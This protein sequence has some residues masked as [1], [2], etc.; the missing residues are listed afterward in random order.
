[1]NVELTLTAASAALLSDDVPGA[2]AAVA[3]LTSRQRDQLWRAAHELA[4]GDRQ[5][6]HAGNVAR[7]FAAAADM[8]DGMSSSVSEIKRRERN[9]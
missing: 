5:P 1:M 6:E 4:A 2:L 3:A 8:L 9:E 7:F